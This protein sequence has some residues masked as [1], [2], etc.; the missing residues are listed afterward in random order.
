[1]KVLSAMSTIRN[2]LT[3]LA[4]FVIADGVITQLLIKGG[5]AH[6]GNPLLSPF[7]ETGT[8]I[9]V[10]VAGALLSA[11]IL[12]DMYQRRPKLA[13]TASSCLVAVYAGIVSW[14]LSLFF[15]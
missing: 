14:N 3:A 4:V 13:L 7:V 15:V 9:V 11:F 8:F 12:W 5:L 10:K 6:E 2:L 1:M